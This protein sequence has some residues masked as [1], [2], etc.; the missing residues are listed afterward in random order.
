MDVKQATTYEEQVNKIIEHGF[1]VEDKENLA[2][3]LK[4]S[5]YYRFSAYF[6]PFKNSNPYKVNINTIHME[7]YLIWKLIYS[8]RNIIMINF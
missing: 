8:I 4:I 7:V 2:N 5:N 3:F 6:L 1:M